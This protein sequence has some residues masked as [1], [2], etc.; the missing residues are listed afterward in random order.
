MRQT[1]ASSYGTGRQV[2]ESQSPVAGPRPTRHPNGYFP[3]SGSSNVSGSTRQLRATPMDGHQLRSPGMEPPP[4]LFY[5]STLHNIYLL[6]YHDKNGIPEYLLTCTCGSIHP[7]RVEPALTIELTTSQ[8]EAVLCK[9]LSLSPFPI[10]RSRILAVRG[11][12]PGLPWSYLRTSFAGF[13]FACVAVWAEEDP[14]SVQHRDALQRDRT[15][16]AFFVRAVP[17]Y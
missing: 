11:G 3:K 1:N 17:V 4:P 10:V 13:Q 5:P 15:S 14:L 16:G 8:M 9:K 2:F 12:A 6:T 7:G